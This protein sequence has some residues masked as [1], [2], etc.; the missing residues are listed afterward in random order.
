MAKEK[1]YTLLAEVGITEADLKNEKTASKTELHPDFI[2]AY[3]EWVKMPAGKQK[4]AIHMRLCKLFVNPKLHDFKEVEIEEQKPEPTQKEEKQEE[5]KL[6]KPVEEAKKEEV[7]PVISPEL[8]EEQKKD[9]EIEQLLS[10]CH[11][12]KKPLTR[13]E[14]FDMGI[15]PDRIL[16]I[17]V[18]KSQFIVRQNVY[19]RFTV[20]SHK[21]FE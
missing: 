19:G 16:L 9:N 1:I 7:P 11:T 6:D 15:K 10:D 21:I 17:K 20:E 13:E 18:N 12:N 4:A 2:K 5:Q 14:L 3:F 8:T